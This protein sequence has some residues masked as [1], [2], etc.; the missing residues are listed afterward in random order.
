MVRC[1]N[2]AWEYANNE[3]G[4]SSDEIIG[5][6]SDRDVLEAIHDSARVMGLLCDNDEEL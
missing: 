6:F 2:E 5:K 3:L 1:R 4:I